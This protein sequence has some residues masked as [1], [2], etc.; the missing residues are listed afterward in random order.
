MRTAAISIISLALTASAT[1]AMDTSE[2]SFY[3]HGD[4]ALPTGDFGDFA[5]MGFGGGV[6]AALPIND[7]LTVRAQAGY[8]HFLGTSIGDLDYSY[9]LI[10]II[11][12]A[13]YQFTPDVPFY[14]M[15][16]VGLTMARASVSGKV[17]GID[18]DESTTD[19]EFGIHAGGGYHLNDQM[20]LEARYNIV[21]DLDYASVHFLYGF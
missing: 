4:F 8:T 10:P 13:E 6:G 14:A 9:G 11:A 7:A 3:V 20:A 15:G 21:G 19:S 17:L 12:L 5:D 18:F 2:L 1:L 16:G